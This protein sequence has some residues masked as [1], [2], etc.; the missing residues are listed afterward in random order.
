MGIKIKSYKKYSITVFIALS[1]I[2]CALILT[3]NTPKAY[4]LKT[5]N[6]FGMEVYYAAPLAYGQGC[7]DLFIFP[8][9]EEFS[10]QIPESFYSEGP[11]DGYIPSGTN[12]IPTYGYLSE[13]GMPKDDIKFYSEDTVNK[14]WT[15]NYILRTMWDNNNIV[16]WY[17]PSKVTDDELASL[18]L[19]DKQYPNAILVL[20]WLEYE[21]KTLPFGRS[22]A[23]SRLGFTQSCERYNFNVM[24]EFANF[25]VEHKIKHAEEPEIAELNHTN[26]L[27]EFVLKPSEQ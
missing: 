20:P 12:I 21:S 2:L 18:K 5:D 26:N 6:S 4:S 11:S 24:A 17:D 3:L 14:N 1:V 27:D 13:R 15:E 22:I 19:L 10:K 8:K 7:G 9:A 23:Y 25:T 16:I